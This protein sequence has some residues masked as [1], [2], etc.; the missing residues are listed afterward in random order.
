MQLKHLKIEKKKLNKKIN[1]ILKSVKILLKK[2]KK[3]LCK[4]ILNNF[5]ATELKNGLKLV[6]KL[7]KNME[8]EIRQ[9]KGFARSTKPKYFNQIW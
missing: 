1:K 9:S 4:N 5:S 6:Q 2:K 8:T 3:N 7:S